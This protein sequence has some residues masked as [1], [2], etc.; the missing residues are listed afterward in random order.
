MAWL[1]NV[2]EAMGFGLI[3]RGWIAAL[4]RQASAYFLLHNISPF[5]LILFSIRQG[6]ALASLLFVLYKEPFLAM[7]EAVL[8]G[9]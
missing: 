5:F 6:D 7:L 4:H 8:Q 1:D 9:L 3:F 2:L